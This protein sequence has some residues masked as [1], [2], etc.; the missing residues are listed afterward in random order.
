MRPYRL[1]RGLAVL[2]AALRGRRTTLLLTND[3][4]TATTSRA[5]LGR[6]TIAQVAALR[7]ALNR[8]TLRYGPHGDV[9]ALR[10]LASVVTYHGLPRDPTFL[11][12]IAPAGPHRAAE[13]VTLGL[14][15]GRL[16]QTALGLIMG[17]RLL[18]R[19]PERAAAAVQADPDL[20]ADLEQ[21]V[22]AAWGRRRTPSLQMGVAR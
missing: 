15:T 21:R 2:Q 10:S 7:L 13:L 19:T 12:D 14:L 4:G 18:G 6:S 5:P 17:E 16:T 9:V 8:Q 3:L 1:D 11:L 20:A 22:R